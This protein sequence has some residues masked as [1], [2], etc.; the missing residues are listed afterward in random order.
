MA[1]GTVVVATAVGGITEQIENGQTGFLVPRKDADEM[2]RIVLLLQ[3]KPPL[4][5]KISQNASQTAQNRF[6]LDSQTLQYLD[7]FHD[8]VKS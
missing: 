2:A 5:T 8:L 6:S 1:C 4:L 3:K 7:W